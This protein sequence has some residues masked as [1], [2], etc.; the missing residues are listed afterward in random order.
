[1][2]HSTLTIPVDSSDYAIGHNT[3][4]GE[5]DLGDVARAACQSTFQDKEAEKAVHERFPG[6][7]IIKRHIDAIAVFS[8]DV[9]VQVRERPFVDRRV[10]AV[11]ERVRGVEALGVL[12]ICPAR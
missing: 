2:A 7:R 12:H 5:V 4:D 8:S 11:E 1:M 9:K 10:V 6:L 3:D